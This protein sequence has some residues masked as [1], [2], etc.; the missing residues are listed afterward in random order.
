M[1]DPRPEDDHA[2]NSG[3]PAAAGPLGQADQWHQAVS[4]VRAVVAW[5]SS[6]IRDLRHAVRAGSDAA[7]L[8]VLTD[9]RQQAL[10]DLQQL[11]NGVEAE[12]A[13]RLAAHYRTVLEELTG[14]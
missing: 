1:H 11:E 9:A 7:D 2:E 13:A 5:Y 3:M 14:G 4:A 12:E 6:G 8:N 10:T